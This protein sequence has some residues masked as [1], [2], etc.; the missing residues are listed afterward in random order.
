MCTKGGPKIPS[1]TFLSPSSGFVLVLIQRRRY[2]S[3]LP[4]LLYLTFPDVPYWVSFGKMDIDHALTPIFPATSTSD[5]ST[6]HH[7]ILP[8]RPS[9]TLRPRY[10]PDRHSHH[11]ASR[12]RARNDAPYNRP[13]PNRPQGDRYDNNNNRNAGP[14]RSDPAPRGGLAGRLG[15]RG[16]G[17][18]PRLSGNARRAPEGTPE[19]FRTG[20]EAIDM[21]KQAAN[22]SSKLRN[23][24]MKAWLRS[25]VLGSGVMDMSVSLN[26][27]SY[28]DQANLSRS[29]PETNTLKRRI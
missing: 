6:L 26:L 18:G 14:S 16:G 9:L 20:D 11:Q 15:G 23:D 2:I 13:P 29:Y 12:P 27:R 10:S 8:T 1:W 5:S 19:L 22:L 21:R 4:S 24:G 28:I 25:R 17:S 3:S 7:H